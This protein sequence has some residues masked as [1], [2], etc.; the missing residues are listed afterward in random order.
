MSI[1]AKSDGF[2]SFSYLKTN[3]RIQIHIFL[4][5]KHSQEIKKRENGTSM[6]TYRGTFLVQLGPISGIDRISKIP[7]TIFHIL[8]MSARVHK[9]RWLDGEFYSER[10]G[11]ESRAGVKLSIC[12]DW[13]CLKILVVFLKVA[14]CLHP[15]YE[16]QYTMLLHLFEVMPTLLARLIV[17][18]ILLMHYPIVN[19]NFHQHPYSNDY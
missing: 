11:Q 9:H 17:I 8:Q 2:P 15:S 13:S 16:K 1:S 14:A 12:M 7:Q 10:R 3:F 18:T 19:D 6:T 5:L 4:W